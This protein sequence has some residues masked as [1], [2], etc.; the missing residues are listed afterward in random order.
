MTTSTQRRLSVSSLVLLAVVFVAA[1]I[2]SNRLFSGWRIDL[3]ANNLYTLSDGTRRIL[4]KIDEPINLYFYYSDQ[5]TENIPSLRDYAQRVRE[6]LEEFESVADGNIRLHVIDPLPF[7]EEEDR[8]A[9]F[10]LQGV[11]LP[12]SPDP[13]YL[14]LAGTNS[15][16]DEEI[17]PFFQPDKAEFL[18]YDIAR[19]VSTLASPERITVGLV[20]GVSMSGDFNPQTRQMQQPWMVYQQAQQLFDIRD[21]GTDFDRI[22]DD[23]S[24]LWIVQP[25][26]LGPRTVYAIDQY[27][28]RGGKA[29]IF[30][31]PVADAD[32]ATPPQGMPQGMPVQGQSSDLPQLFD[33]WGIDYAPG[34]VV[35]DARLALQL[36][37][38]PGQRPVRH[39]AFLG[40]TEEQLNHEDVTTA[41]LGT[42]NLAMAGSLSQADGSELQF[43]PLISSS[44]ASST[45]RSTRFSYLPDPAVLQDGFTPGGVPQV[46]AARISGILTSAFPDG[47]PPR[48]DADSATENDAADEQDAAAQEAAH[49][50]KGTEAANII[51]VADVDMLSDR[52]WVQVQNFFGQQVANAFAGNGAFATNALENL[53]G[54]SD[55]IAVRSR[56]SY[57]RPFTRV[58][59]LRAEADARFRETEQRLQ[60]ELSETERRLG[61]LQSAREDTGELLLTEEQQQEIDRFID[62]RA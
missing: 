46:L 62:Q 53:S 21:L 22:A 4:G 3:T 10:G 37:G 5:A 40:I 13:V 2:I 14:G 35:T 60:N 9:Q 61:E 33:A 29:L 58:E 17:I 42:L 24:L 20:A 23:V 1:V 36:S 57:S 28:L 16:D 47:P 25:K 26:N 56:G 38:G 18:E 27:L 50:A 48:A 39:L 52:L 55:L 51:V 19:L 32:P 34:E 31:D 8:A 41:D 30:V 45:V 7:S 59:R 44:P 15:V 49:L 12:A 6:L 54:S 43:E 11:Q